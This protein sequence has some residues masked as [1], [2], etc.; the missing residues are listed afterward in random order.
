M[1]N[2]ES[3]LSGKIMSNNNKNTNKN[4]NYLT[5]LDCVFNIRNNNQNAC[6]NNHFHFI[7]QKSNKK[8]INFYINY[9]PSLIIQNFIIRKR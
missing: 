1:K 2:K 7:Q 9:Y 5:L 6:F 4:D 8:Q 3:N